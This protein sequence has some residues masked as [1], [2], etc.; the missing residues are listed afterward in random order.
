MRIVKIFLPGLRSILVL[1]LSACTTLSGEVVPPVALEATAAGKAEA[2]RAP[3]AGASGTATRAPAGTLP[4]FAEVTKDAKQSRGYIPV[5]AKNEKIW[6]ELLPEHFDRLFFFGSSSASGLG[7]PAF[8]PGLMG[9]EQVVKFR[10]VGNSVQLIAVNLAVRAPTGTPLDLAVQESYSD[11]LLA[12]APV[13]SQSHPDR[14]SILVDASVLVLGDLLGVEAALGVTYGLAYSLDRANST[15]MRTRVTEEGIFVTVRSH[16]AV[17]RLPV[18]R[19]DATPSEPS[20]SPSRPAS[21]PRY[22]PD[23]RSLFLSFTYSFTPLPEEPMAPRLAD[24]RV[25]YFTDAFLDFGNSENGDRRTHVIARWRLEKKDPLAGLSEPKSPIR[26]VMDKNIPEK[27][28]EPVRAGILEWNK[29]FE[30]AGFKNALV[31]EQQ[32]SDAD[33]SSL[34]GVRVLAVRWFAL[35]GPGAVAVGLSQTD[36][37]TGEILRGAAIIPE[38]FVLLGRSQVAEQLPQ[39][40]LGQPAFLAWALGGHERQCSYAHGALEHAE[41]GYALLAARGEMHPSSP[42]SDRFI[43]ARLKDVAM[44][45]IG[46]ALGLRHNFKGSIGV[47]PSDLRDGRFVAQYGI[48]NSVMDYNALNLPLTGEPATAYNQTTLGRY[49][50]WAIEYGYKVLPKESER[51]ELDKLA[52]QSATDL[53]LI[54]ATDEDAGS[55]SNQGIDPTANLFDLGNDPLAYAERQFKLV[56]ELWARTERWQLPSDNTLAV[57]RRNLQRGLL[58]YA[59]SVSLIA[60]YVGGVYTSRDTAGAGSA[61]FM[62][63]PADSQRRALDLLARNVFAADSFRFDPTFLSRL[64]YDHLDRIHGPN[65]TNTVFGL[66]GAVLQVQRR[67]LDVLMSESV[68]VRLADA[69]FNTAQP[70]RLLNYGELQLLLAGTIWS[71]LGRVPSINSFRRNLQREHVKRVA[72]GLLRP[73]SAAAADVRAVHRIVAAKLAA[74]MKHA[75]AGGQ[76]DVITRAHL[77][78]SQQ[79]LSEALRAPLVRQGM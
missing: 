9:R 58:L 28:R 29:A 79:T 40:P 3:S 60:K 18:P 36:P 24:Q 1:V 59:Q 21:S 15:I 12:V 2:T 63:V 26:V 11:S 30:R 6:L 44:H 45:E 56:R 66:S 14:S 32:P 48:S 19:L 62:P 42:E 35:D 31:V 57:N 53:A 49:D 13:A 70:S 10:R 65:V 38:N 43:A 77:A 55:L 73:T 71:E 5:W 54:Y 16:Y 78:E 17:P 72:S 50:Y 27:W 20:P 46:H 37:R 33:W 75:L 67:A 51:T 23:P 47:Q 64:G 39:L 41:F 68:A 8:L 4:A 34:E 69:E 7:T 61:V 52:G 22:L 25:G 74:D 76:L